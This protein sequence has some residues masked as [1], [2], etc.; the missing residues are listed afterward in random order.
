[1]LIVTYLRSVQLTEDGRVAPS[2]PSRFI[3][4]IYNQIVDGYLVIVKLFGVHCD[5]SNL[6]PKIEMLDLFSNM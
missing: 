4:Y 2:K 6:T 5:V 1:M 3:I